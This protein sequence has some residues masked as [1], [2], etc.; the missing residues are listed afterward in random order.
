MRVVLLFATL[1]AVAWSPASAQFD[2]I[3]VFADPSMSSCKISDGGG[4]VSVY[5]VHTTNGAVASQ[6]MVKA[7]SGVTLTWISDT[8]A[9]PAALGTTQS[10]ISVGYGA[11]FSSDVLV[12]TVKYLAS[13]TSSSC[14]WL[15]IAP[16]PSSLKQKI[17]VVNC[18]QTTVDPSVSRLVINSDGSCDCGPTSE[19][20]NWGKIKSRYED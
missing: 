11:C 15:S 16:D 4:M 10:G 20:T 3:G 13:G 14:S 19:L 6:F 5:V 1:A 17:E 12:A 18:S 2:V 7:S 9:F 8:V